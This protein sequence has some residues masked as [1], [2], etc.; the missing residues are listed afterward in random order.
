MRANARLEARV[1][2]PPV[3]YPIR[4]FLELCEALDTPVALSCWM[5]VQ[6]GEWDDLVARKIRPGDYNDTL[7]FRLDYQVVSVLS[8][9]EFLATS[10]D[11]REAAKQTFRDAEVKCA[12]TNELLTLWQEGKVLPRNKPVMATLVRAAEIIRQ[13]LGDRPNPL[14]VPE[15]R[16]GPGSTS[17][18]KRYISAAE[19]YRRQVDVTPSLYPY[20]QDIAGPSWSREIESVT[21]NASNRVT[22][23]PK[24]AKTFRTIAVEP[25]LN[26]YAQLG[27]ASLLRRRLRRVG[28]DLTVQADVNRW[29]ASVAEE[30]N[31]ATIDLSAASDTVSRQIVWALLP[32]A[33]AQLLDTARCHYGVLDGVEFE[34]EKFSSMG[35]GFTFELETLLFYA[36]ARASGS[37]EALTAV[38]GDDI[39]CESQVAGHLIDVLDFC[40]FKVNGDKTFLDG[41]FRESCGRDYFRGEDVRPFFWKD[42]DVPLWFKVPN[43]LRSLAATLRTDTLRKARLKAA[44]FN[45]TRRLPRYLDRRVPLGYDSFGVVDRPPPNLLKT[46]QQKLHGWDGFCFKGVSFRARAVPIHS[47]LGAMLHA[48]DGGDYEGTGQTSFRGIGSWKVS[49]LSAF[50]TWVDDG[51]FE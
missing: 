27:I 13:I 48:L 5:Q 15:F 14:E 17:L 30:W 26:G 41:A 11:R 31:L 7:S 49:T 38:F 25:H 45:A 37:H 32:E 28:I 10:Y 9:A 3:S 43:S 6:Y 46:E 19:K 29:F 42:L 51:A 24:N 2:P 20:W 12:Q 35:N 22:F 40:G 18:V 4:A 23:V 1:M 33:W 34:Y 50:G 44:W 8:K 16:F 36:L 21:L 47:H 39:I